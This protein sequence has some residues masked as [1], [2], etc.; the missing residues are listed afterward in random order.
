M[1]LKLKKAS[2]YDAKSRLKIKMRTAYLASRHKKTPWYAKAL[3]VAVVGYAFSPV[4]LLPDFI[5]FLGYLDDIIIVP[6]GLSLALKMVPPDVL[7]E[8]RQ[9]AREQVNK[10]TQKGD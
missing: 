1:A 10:G 4:D 9:Q 2:V 3:A 6:I 7:E 8:C 5:P